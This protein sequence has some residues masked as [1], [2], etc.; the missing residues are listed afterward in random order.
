MVIVCEGC[1]IGEGAQK[2]DGGREGWKQFHSLS[3][4]CLQNN[5]VFQI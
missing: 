3:G 1:H 4:L 2:W 5:N